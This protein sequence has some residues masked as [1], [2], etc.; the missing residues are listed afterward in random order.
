[1]YNIP[2]NH[3][4]TTVADTIL[5]AVNLEAPANNTLNATNST[6][7]FYFNTT[8]NLDTALECTLWL[9][10]T[11]VGTAA[12]YGT[13]TSVTNGTS[14]TIKANVSLSNND[15]YWWVN[16]TDGT[17]TNVSVSYNISMAV[18]NPNVTTLLPAAGSVFNVSNVFEISANIT[19][20]QKINTAIANVSYPNGT[21]RE[22]TL[23]NGSNYP[24]K[25]NVSFTTTLAGNYTTYFFANDSEGNINNTPSTTF[26]IDY[27]F[28]FINITSI[29]GYANGTRTNLFFNG[30]DSTN[31]LRLRSPS[32]NGSFLSQIFDVVVNGTFN[33]ISWVSSAYGESPSNRETETKFANGNLNMSGNMIL[34]HFNNDSGFGENRSLVYDFSGNN[35]NGTWS[36]SGASN[37]TPRLG[38]FSGEFKG[39]TEYA[40][41][42]NMNTEFV[43]QNLTVLAWVMTDN[44]AP[45]DNKLIFGRQQSVSEKQFQGGI[46]T[47]GTIVF[48]TFTTCSTGTNLNSREVLKVGEWY[49][50]A[51]LLN[52]SVEKKIY[53]NGEENNSATSGPLTL[54]SC[55]A[56]PTAI[57]ANVRN[58]E[59]TSW[60]GLIDEVAIFNRTLSPQEIKDHYRRGAMRLNITVR[61]CNDAACSGESFTDINDTS[62]QQ[63]STDYSIAD[64][65]W[66]QYNV[67]FETFNRTLTPELYNIS[68]LYENSSAANTLPTSPILLLLANNS[69]TTNRTPGFLWNNSND[70]DGD[71]LTYNLVIDD[72]SA[73]N[74]PEVNVTQIAQGTLNTSYDITTELNVDTTY[75]WKVAANDSTG[76]GAWS[77]TSNFTVQSY[78]LITLTT[79]SVAFGSVAI[80]DRNDTT[81]NAPPP[82]TAINNGNIIAN[83]T[84]TATSYF[85]SAS[86]PGDAYQFKIRANESSSF[87]TTNS[88][89]SFI[90]MSSSY[91]GY[92]VRGLKWQDV[93]DDFLVDLN[94]TVPSAEPPGAKSSTVTF[95]MEG[96]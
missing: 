15:Y 30:S 96:G 56:Q 78:L 48:S 43:G 20:L 84:I 76:Y 47:D 62:P 1:M 88:N 80:N 32:A 17:N 92:H 49:H 71:T 34:Y 83:V 79:S 40:Y 6:P 63:L 27:N 70:S 74:N 29:Y 16:C 19:D 90:N 59:T 8:D 2:I 35:W 91:T 65:Q 72:N 75:Y 23:S 42:A 51:F 10:D 53:I 67:S 24:D 26:D 9:N 4:S 41:T 64:N 82:F 25:F 85:S 36:G 22:F 95:T 55:G 11:S 81:D 73:F 61:S 50:V 94:I 69:Y 58:P 39:G 18:D 60:D 57:G 66:F 86:F 13:N 7:L 33:N 93:N 44:A 77:N 37:G 52:H 89:T 28:T 54:E 5:P 46:D 45:S 3:P 38:S 68:I 12:A 87:D 31:Y 21:L 14:A